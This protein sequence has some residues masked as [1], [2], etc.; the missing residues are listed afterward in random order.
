[1][2]FHSEQAM[3]F[4]GSSHQSL[5]KDIARYLGV[6]LG[7]AQLTTF[8]DKEISVQILDSVRGRD[9]F[10]IQ[11]V[12]IE[13]NDMLME[14]LITI[15]ALKRASARSI[16][17]VI[18]YYGY[19]RQDRKDK[20]R[21]PITAKLVADM[22]EVAG[23]N[24]VLTM[25]LHAN[26]VQGFFNVPVDNLYAR[27]RLVQA[28]QRRKLQDFVVVAPDS[29]SI[30]LARA[31]ASHLGTEIAI[32]DKRRRDATSV[33][34][35]TVIGDVADKDVIL[36]DDICSTAGTLVK[37]AEVCRDYGAKRV[38][39]AVTHALMVGE[40]IE[41]LNN[42]VIEEIFVSDSIPESQWRSCDKVRPVSIAP[43]FG[44]AM[45]RVLT[46]ES[47]S[48]LFDVRHSQVTPAALLDV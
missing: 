3:I 5:A 39:A 35:S 12:V 45:R 42:S 11:S 1:M 24:R 20:P 31:F 23:V 46:G 29:G 6:E 15:D 2:G 21:V 48:T 34:V 43:V 41:R 7:R 28:I 47:I 17:A 36:V 9:V 25:D 37:A 44:E 19:C 10:I 8:P 22:L 32:V 26:Q 18:P 33:E 14:L 16:V 4:T 30:K 38:F 40:A 13:P 27:P